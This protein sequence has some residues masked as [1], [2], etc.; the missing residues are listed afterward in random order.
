MSEFFAMGG[1]AAFIWPCY[2]LAVAVMIFLVVQSVRTMRANEK[3]VET[4]RS[5]RRAKAT[6]GSASGQP[7]SDEKEA[8]A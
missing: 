3:L 7:T 6:E 4:L 5:G 2:G 8:K 1:H